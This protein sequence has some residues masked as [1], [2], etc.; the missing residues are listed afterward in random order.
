MTASA[1]A[2][3]W[4]EEWVSPEDI[5][6]HAPWQVRRNLDAA[7]V[8]KYRDMTKAGSTPP[9]IKL[10][11]VRGKLYLVDGWHRMEAGALQ[12]TRGLDGQEVLAEVAPMSDGEARWAAAQANLGHGVP[13]KAAELHAVFKAYIKAKQHLKPDGTLRSYRDMAPIIGKPHTTIRTWM[14]KYFPAV[15]RQ[16]A[17]ERG[18]PEPEMPSG[19]L[20]DPIAENFH[21]ACEGILA[22]RQRLDILTP[23]DRWDLVNQ[24][25]GA[26]E[27]ALR[28]GVKEPPSEDF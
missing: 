3:S 8:K 16:M 4:A 7:A 12:V 14:L 24:L 21:A 11:R 26:R 17:G 25:E 23:E 22:V 2:V 5:I 20:I 18:N 13:L 28:L 15:A 9:P 10:A 19:P 1:Q 6:K 27:E